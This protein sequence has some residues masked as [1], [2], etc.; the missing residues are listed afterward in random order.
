MDPCSLMS[1]V[2]YPHILG[3]TEYRLLHP[4]QSPRPQF[5]PGLSPRT[6]TWASLSAE[7]EVDM[8]NDGRGSEERI[9]VPSCYGGIGAPVS[10][11]GENRGLNR[12]GS[13]AAGEGLRE[14]ARPRDSWT[15]S[16]LFWVSP[17]SQAALLT[18]PALSPKGCGDTDPRGAQMGLTGKHPGGG[19]VEWAWAQGRHGRA[20]S[21]FAVGLEEL[22]VRSEC[23]TSCD[24][25]DKQPPVSLP[26]L[27]L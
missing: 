8:L 17:R 16:C 12:S 19:R 5:P 3:G 26:P 13:P 7:D 2:F 4:G 6:V 18:W 15:Y 25:L 24:I 27:P 11:Q 20:G 21:E 14:G 22:G 1:H 23:S 10:R 9:S